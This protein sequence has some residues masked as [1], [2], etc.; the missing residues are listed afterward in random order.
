MGISFCYHTTDWERIHL[1]SGAPTV[2]R[3]RNGREGRA[4]TNGTVKFYRI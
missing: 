2:W 1:F 3:Q 4:G